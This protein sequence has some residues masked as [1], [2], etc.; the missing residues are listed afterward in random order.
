MADKLANAAADE[1]RMGKQF[2][3]DQSDDCTQPFTAKYWM[4]QTI[5]IQTAEG[6]AETKVLLRDLD[7]SIKRRLCMSSMIWATQTTV[8]CTFSCGIR[9]NHSESIHIVM[10]CGLYQQFQNCTRETSRSTRQEEDHSLFSGMC[11]TCQGNQ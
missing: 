5:Q 7:D 1:C 3:Y 11:H 10:H 6:P 9:R 4:Q 2:E 8:H